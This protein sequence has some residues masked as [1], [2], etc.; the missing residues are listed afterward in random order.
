MGKWHL[1]YKTEYNPVHQGFD[2]FYGFVSGN[3]DYFSHYDNAGIYDW[4]HNTDSLY[5]EG[6]S[7]DLITEHALDFI[8]N[9]KDWPFFLYVPHEAPHVPFQGRRDS[10]YRYPDRDFSYFGPVE[11]RHRAYADMMIALDEGVGRILEKVIQENL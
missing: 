9:N 7:T 11:D 8:E 4:W 10:A 6:Y 5:E 1:G 3:I 2:Q